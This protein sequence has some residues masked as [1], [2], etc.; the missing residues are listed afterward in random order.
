M[1]VCPFDF[2][3]NL[4][5]IAVKL[6]F[7]I[8]SG[9]VFQRSAPL[10]MT[11][12]ITNLLTLLFGNYNGSFLGNSYFMYFLSNCSFLCLAQQ[13]LSSTLLV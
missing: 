8:L 1:Q 5:N 3:I 9:R 7:V 4:L 11:E 13:T 6:A 2:L 10:N 12:L